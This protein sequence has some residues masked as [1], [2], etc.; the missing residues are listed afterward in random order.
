MVKK[1]KAHRIS[2]KLEKSN[3][4]QLFEQVK[5]LSAPVAR[6]LP[7]GFDNDESL[8]NGFAEYFYDKVDKITA[9]FDDSNNADMDLP[10]F[11]GVRFDEFS[12]LASNEVNKLRKIK[13][14]QLDIIPQL[15]F[16][17]VWQIGRA[18]CRERV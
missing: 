5:S 9:D 15:Y 16:V 8:A 12:P 6:Y 11:N 18:S 1:H 14:S 17:S 4:R 2:L 13:C 10:S 7:S 3:P